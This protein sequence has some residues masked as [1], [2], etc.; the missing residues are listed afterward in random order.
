[1][2]LWFLV[3]LLLVKGLVDGLKRVFLK[4]TYLRI[5][6]DFPLIPFLPEKSSFP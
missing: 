3:G 2:S 1:L 6:D 5:D 4:V